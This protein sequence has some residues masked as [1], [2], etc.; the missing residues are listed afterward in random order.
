MPACSAEAAP[1]SGLPLRKSRT[2]PSGRES[3]RQKA[4][5]T[6]A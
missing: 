3:Q 6:C 1:D 5:L 2:E 4:A